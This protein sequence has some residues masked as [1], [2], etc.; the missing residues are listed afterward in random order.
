MTTVERLTVSVSS[1]MAEML[2][3]TV[4]GGEYASASEIVGEALG[5]WRRERDAERRK[6]E[7]LRDAVRL[8]LESGPGVPAE[9]VYAELRGII[10]KRRAARG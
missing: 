8:G 4:E 9:E 1:E 2:R 6:L 3:E 5:E 10:A 7:T